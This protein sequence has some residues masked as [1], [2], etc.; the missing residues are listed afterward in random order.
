M[1]NAFLGQIT[2]FGGNY[3]P[4]NT[5]FCNGQTLS[6][7]QNTALFSLLGTTYG[8][9]GSTTFML[10]NLQSRVSIHQGQGAGLSAYTLGQTAGSA[11]VTI[12]Q[13]TLPI[14]QHALNATQAI[15]DSPTIASNK[16]PGQPTVGNPPAFYAFQGPPP[17]PTLVPHPMNAAACSTVGGSQ[18]HSNLMPSQCITFVIFLQGIFPSRD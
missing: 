6:I 9:N 15:A 18:G 16:L 11:S 1:S 10:P 13:S 8:G 3:A 2:M 7:Q 14:H 5:A 4:R 17:L 12:N